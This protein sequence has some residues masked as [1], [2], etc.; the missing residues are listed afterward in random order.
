MDSYTITVSH[1]LATDVCPC[2]SY[3][4]YLFLHDVVNIII[5]LWYTCAS[6]KF[7]QST[8]YHAIPVLNP[9]RFSMAS[10]MGSYTITVSHNIIIIS[11]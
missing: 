6:I 11:N 9:V 10:L 5:K 8:P 3:Y 7:S 4:A 1:I 2:Y